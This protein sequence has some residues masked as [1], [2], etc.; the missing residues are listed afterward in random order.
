MSRSSH[1]P[2]LF[3]PLND[4]VTLVAALMEHG[5]ESRTV[6]IQRML[7]ELKRSGANVTREA[8]AVGLTPHVW[9]DGMTEFYR[10]TK[11]FLY[12]CAVW[13]R[14]PLKNAIRRWI[15]D[16]VRREELDSARVLVFGDG[17][18]FDS[19][20]LAKAGCRVT[21]LEPSDDAAAFGEQVFA[22]NNV[23][24]SRITAMEQIAPGGYDVV[25]CLDVLEHLPSPP[26]FVSQFA[27]WLRPGGFL[28]THSPFFFVEPYQPTHLASNLKHSGDTKLFKQAGLHPYA[29]RFF[30]DP[31]VLQKGDAPSP[32]RRTT[33]LRL[34]QALLWT[35]RFIHPIHA[36]VARFLSGGELSWAR[37][38][39]AMLDEAHQQSATIRDVAA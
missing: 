3:L 13:N 38:L 19:T 25:V 22:L 16:F 28:I 11:A 30:W 8:R 5:G 21:F 32:H 18:G 29:G 10:T 23:N 4:N 15:G 1:P 39:Q 31:I 27:D 6:V 7:D 35:G 2:G 37:E 33:A 17:M 14:S 24:V 26:D 12:A 9:S 20:F 34:G 36:L